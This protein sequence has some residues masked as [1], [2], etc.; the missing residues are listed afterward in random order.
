[1]TID[2]VARAV[3]VEPAVVE[4]WEADLLP[5]AGLHRTA[6][7]RLINGLMQQHATS[8]PTAPPLTGPGTPAAP[9]SASTP[10]GP[11]QT[12]PPARR[13]SRL[14]PCRS[15]AGRAARLQAPPTRCFPP[16]RWPSWTP[17]ARG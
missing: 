15:A 6:Y 12:P 17:A 2:Q 16:G 5:P 9:L 1:V 13:A 4:A 7:A 8:Q 14:P 3:H 10:A 11:G